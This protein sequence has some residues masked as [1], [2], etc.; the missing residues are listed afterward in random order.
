MN[1]IWFLRAL[2][3]ILILALIGLG[4]HHHAEVSALEQSLESAEKE[5]EQWYGKYIRDN[6]N[7]SNHNN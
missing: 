5:N 1:S 6:K 2:I 4:L 3:M 7:E